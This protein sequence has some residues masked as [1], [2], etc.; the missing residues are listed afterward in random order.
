MDTLP[1]RLLL[2]GV[3]LLLSCITTLA[4]EASIAMRDAR[5]KALAEEGNVRALRLKRLLDRS[6]GGF[7]SATEFLSLFL[8][9]FLST[10]TAYAFA[11]PISEMLEN[12]VSIHIPMIVIVIVLIL[13]SL[14]FY[15][16]IGVFIPKSFAAKSAEKLALS[17]SGFTCLIA[18]VCRPFVWL[19]T[20]VAHLIVRLFGIQP[21]DLEEE[22]TEEEI[23]M[24]LDIGSESG[25]IDDDEKEMIH[26]I[27][28]LDDKPVEEIMT[29]RTDVDILWMEDSVDEWEQTIN[30]TNHTRYPVCGDAVDDVIG[31]LVTRDFY[32]MLLQDRNS[33]RKALL[34]EPFF[35]PETIK[36]NELFSQMQ[37]KNAHFTVV[38]DEYGGFCGIVT[39]EDILEE[40]V[41][42]LYSEYD[43]PEQEQ[44]IVKID[45]NTWKIAGS[46][47]M[48]DV[49]EALQVK[50]EEG[51]YN[52]FAGMILDVLGTVPDDGA[53][54]EL[55]TQGLKIKVTK[56]VEHRIEETLVCLLQEVETEESEKKN[57]DKKT[58][59]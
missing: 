29:P 1:P 7:M 35:V 30:E 10:Y 54:V 17:L 55:E 37:D 27:F 5:L 23:R 44:E 39:Q 3:L 28:E 22:V 24:M 2:L 12:A 13:I 16:V 53:A 42:E 57:D 49:E 40:I 47:D 56:I 4:R 15:L 18:A 41:G 59:G 25:V 45:E 58:A 32:R 31:V 36:A 38:L 14:F 9:F 51:E 19:P 20:A 11:Y 34:R 50:L 46:A 43:V 8:G 52:T 6:S 26:N 48:E 21:K 33:D